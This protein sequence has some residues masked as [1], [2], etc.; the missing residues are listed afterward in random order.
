EPE[1]PG[2][3]GGIFG[4]RPPLAIIGAV[5]AVVV[6][7]IVVVAVALG[8]GDDDGDPQASASPGASGGLLTPTLP[9]PVGE[10]NVGPT[11]EAA[12]N[13]PGIGAED[14]MVVEKFGINAPL[15]FKTVAAD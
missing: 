14:R 15:S 2:G 11:V 4:G 13:L 10:L 5:I 12:P 8:G 1:N 9:T 6:L 3:S 7:G